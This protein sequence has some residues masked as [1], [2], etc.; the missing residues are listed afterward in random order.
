LPEPWLQQRRRD[1]YWKLAKKEGYRSR[2][3]FKLLQANKSYHFIKPSGVIVDLGAAPGG[4][5]QVASEIVG[6]H[7][8]VLGV[9]LLPIRQFNLTNMET[10]IGDVANL[11][12]VDKI[13]EKLPRTADAVLCDASPNISGVWEVDHARQIDLARASMEIAKTILQPNGAFFTKIFQGDLMDEFLKEMKQSFHQV[14]IVKPEAS[15]KKSSEIYALGL[16][17]K[18]REAS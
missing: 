4:W 15:K 16:G 3:A 2:A 10:L 13:K 1:Y 11:S 18:P 6:D 12:T 5:M 7:G 14:R 17:L 8:Y 9:D